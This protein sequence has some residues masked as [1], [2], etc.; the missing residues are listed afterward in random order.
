MTSSRK[1]QLPSNI[2]ENGVIPPETISYLVARCKNR[3]YNYVLLKFMEK[4]E[5]EG[6]TKAELARR[7]GKRPEVINRLLGAPGN[8]GLETVTEL[9]AGIS[10]EELEPNSSTLSK[11]ASN[12]SYRPWLSDVQQK[13]QIN[14]SKIAV[15]LSARATITEMSIENGSVNGPTTNSSTYTSMELIS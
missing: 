12:Y 1:M 11:A 6:L 15:P 5:K 7:L 2:F 4:V 8:W 13:Q 14:L 9:L 3:V 10:Q